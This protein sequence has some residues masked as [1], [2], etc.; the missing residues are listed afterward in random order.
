MKYLE[1][2]L[3]IQ[4]ELS[5]MCNALCLGCIR[6]DEKNFS[7]VAP[8]IPKKTIISLDTF[9]NLIKDPYFQNTPGNTVQFCGTVDDPLM[10]PQWLEI[11]EACVRHKVSRVDIHTNAGTRS[12]EEWR[13][14]KRILQKMH[15]SHDTDYQSLIRFNIDGLEDTNHLYRQ[16]VSWKKVMKNA[17]AFLENGGGKY[18]RWQFLEFPWNKHQIDQAK[19]LAYEMGFSSFTVR[20]DRSSIVR[21]GLQLD[22][23]KK[24]QELY[25]SNRDD[26]DSDFNSYNDIGKFNE[27]HTIDQEIGCYFQA[28]GMVFVDYES[29]VWPCCFFR[30]SKI[31]SRGSRGNGMYA[32]I[33]NQMY[34][35][36]Q[37]QDWNRLDKNSLTEIMNHPYYVKDLTDSWKEKLPK[38][39]DDLGPNSWKKYLA[40]NND[41]HKCNNFKCVQTC[42]KKNQKVMTVGGHKV[43]L[44]WKYKENGKVVDQT[45][46]DDD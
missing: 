9:E 35:Q 46:D 23:I 19:Q 4:I 14:M 39:D 6:T 41:A 44:L 26:N 31:G 27:L 32:Q 12:P 13:E 20:H 37:D 40:N 21:K 42:G 45:R 2:I 7:R 43:E 18:A 5:S 33:A 36:Y 8:G 24:V 25:N 3:N 11:L 1:Q 15:N 16:N 28:D 17:E 30:N 29:R 34:D 10:H 22:D 38:L